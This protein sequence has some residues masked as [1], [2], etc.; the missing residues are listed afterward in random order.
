M[1]ITSTCLNCNKTISSPERRIKY[2]KAH[3]LPPVKYCSFT[4]RIQYKHKKPVMI[5]CPV[6]GKMFQQKRNTQCCSHTCASSLRVQV[7]IKKIPQR[8]CRACHVTF[9]SASRAFCNTCI[10]SKR[11]RYKKFNYRLP[12]EMCLKDVIKREGANRYDIIRFWARNSILNIEQAKCEK[13]GYSKHV[14]VAHKKAISKYPEDSSIATVN[15]R[16]NI[17]LL[18]PNCHWEF[19]HS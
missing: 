6:C 11:S 18:C 2:R 13:C 9:K 19:D 5:P 16:D 15:S 17:M 7:H 4:C 12:S 1:N 10:E 8:V 14:E 3:N